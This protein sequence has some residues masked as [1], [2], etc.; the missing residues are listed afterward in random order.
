M[1]NLK[2]FE[3]FI[4]EG[5]LTDFLKKNNWETVFSSDV[6]SRSGDGKLMLQVERSKNKYRCVAYSGGL[7]MKISLDRLLKTFP[8]AAA[9]ARRENINF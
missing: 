6:K 3:K 1:E 5:I 4:N 8:E 2:K 7:T 9:I